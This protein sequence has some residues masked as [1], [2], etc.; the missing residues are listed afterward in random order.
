MRQHAP[1]RG[2]FSGASP[3]N[4]YV[5][6]DPVHIAAATRIGYA[7]GRGWRAAT[8][9]LRDQ[10]NPP[11]GMVSR[12]LTRLGETLYDT[13]EGY[14]GT[15]EIH[16][17]T[18]GDVVMTL[19]HKHNDPTQLTPLGMLPRDHWTWFTTVVSTLFAVGL[20]GF[21][22]LGRTKTLKLIPALANAGLGGA[23]LLGARNLPPPAR[24]MIPT[25]A[26]CSAGGAVV[27]L[28]QSWGEWNNMLKGA[29]AGALLGLGLQF[30]PDEVRARIPK[31]LNEA[32]QFG[33]LW[34]T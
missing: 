24:R 23:L 1:V 12:W 29:L 3:E 28:L 30:L 17:P 22:V 19:V 8:A 13:R 10:L 4:P 26:K 18:D 2:N 16:R 20:S 15:T 6:R 27:G 9:S 14:P 32:I 11:L 21:S 31:N 5:L 25:M 34:F 7:L 33:F